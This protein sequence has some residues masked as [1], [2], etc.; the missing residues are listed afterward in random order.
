MYK[1]LLI[2]IGIVAVAV[3]LFW[4]F[5]AVQEAFYDTAIFFER[6]VRQNELLGFFIF[7]LIAILSALL[8]PLTNIPLIPVAVALWGVAPTMIILFIG[9]IIGDIIAYYAG[10]HIGGPLFR[11]IISIKRFDKWVVEIQKHTRF[12]MLLL[13]R[14]ALPAELGYAFGI[15]RYPFA[16]YMAITFLA[17]IPF[18]LI[19]TYASEAI[20]AGERLK[21]FSLIAV[22]IAV[23]LVAMH[24]V[25]ERKT[26][27]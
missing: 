21:F 22:L 23:F 25:R 6:Y 27:E 26:T 11:Y 8:S 1:R 20:L 5:S 13:L 15:M 10:R 4:Y 14:I 3:I 16:K 24:I 7:L 17:E 9:W 19:T 18:V 12:Y 2:I